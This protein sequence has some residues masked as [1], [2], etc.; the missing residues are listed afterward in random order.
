MPDRLKKAVL[1]VAALAALGL[2]AGALAQ[3]GPDGQQSGP[4][5]E[6][7]SD[8]AERE[9][10]AADPDKVQHEN[11]GFEQGENGDGREDE[12]G[13]GGDDDKQATGP[14]AD[15]A[16]SA[17]IDIAGGGTAQSVEREDEGRAVWEV[18]VKRPDGKTVEVTLDGNYNS[19]AVDS[20]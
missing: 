20:E 13:E 9:N 7:R 16:K 1:A 12:R 5:S 6:E 19:V 17:A 14:A 18:E 10:S 2:G 3:A 8:G 11:E 4:K 15:R